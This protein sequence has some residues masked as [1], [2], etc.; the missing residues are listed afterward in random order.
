MYRRLA[1]GERRRLKRQKWQRRLGRFLSKP[2]NAEATKG[3]L[4]AYRGGRGVGGALRWLDV[5]NG[6]GDEVV[7]RGGD[8]LFKETEGYLLRKLE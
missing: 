2:N 3:V 4:E 5:V 6:A 8:N 7:P 1:D